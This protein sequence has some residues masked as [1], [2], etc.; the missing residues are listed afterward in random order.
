MLPAAALAT[1][2]WAQA[3]GDAAVGPRPTTTAAPPAPLVAPALAPSPAAAPVAPALAPSPAAAP[4]APA[5]APSPASPRLP[6]ELRWEAPAGC[7]DAT[8]VRAAITRG[9]PP[10][11]TGTEPMY[12]AVLVRALDA[13]HWQA[14]LA[15]R[16]ADWT[17]TRTLK[18]PTCAAVSDAAAL[19]IGLALTSDLQ[20]REV[21]VAPPPPRARSTPAVALA[22]V[23]DVGTLSTATPGGA[24]A[25]G[26]RFA[27][28]R[29][30]LRGSLF[31]SRAGAVSSAPDTGARI[32]LASLDARACTLRGA[33]WSVGPCGAAGVDR[34]RGTGTGPITTG[35]ITSFAP[36]LAGGL[37]GEWRLSRWVVPFLTAE[38]AI[39]LVRGRFSVEDVGQVH[40]AA[41]VL[42][43]GAA[44]LELRF[45]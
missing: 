6:L 42:V 33:T 22:F 43:R 36:F 23:G 18:G 19:V 4:V 29:V 12:A 5:L 30:E 35:G 28:A 27:R 37:Q 20:A 8:T 3:G 41:A 1:I 38:A 9:V 17:A 39:P 11:P 32:S 31:A 34:L 25:L 45:Q 24:L 15:L 13:E 14:A 7:P 16:G 2:L 26:W 21:V 40:Q 44:G 10:S